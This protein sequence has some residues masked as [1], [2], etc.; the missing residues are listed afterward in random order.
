[1]KYLLSIV[2]WP[3]LYFGGLS[4]TYFALS[5]S[6]P[7][8]WFNVIYFV[9]VSL[10][11]V[12]ERL[13]PHSTDWLEPDGETINNIAHTLLTKGLV[14]A[15]AMIGASFPMVL[16]LVALPP[17]PDASSLWPHAWPMPVQVLLALVIAEFGLYSAHRLA[18]EH[19]A[20]WRFHALHHSVTRL[21]VVNTGRFHFLDSL[22]KIVVSP[23]PLY[24]LGAP[25]DVF[26][27]VGAVTAYT[28][29]LTHCNVE[30]RTGILDYV[31]STP[32][33]HRWHHSINLEE[34]NKNYGENL[35]V[36]DLLLGTYFNPNRPS[37]TKIGITGTVATNF[38]GQLRQP[39]TRKG[40]REIL[41]KRPKVEQKRRESE[42]AGDVGCTTSTVGGGNPLGTAN[43]KQNPS[44]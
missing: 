2:L 36:W 35:V 19:L 37:S 18:H 24:L 30:M 16:A 6:K 43:I 25:L 5:S 27:W 9:F 20:L 32:R 44:G 42:A 21:W 22:F 1:M 13:M 34:G 41:G 26:L 28:G 8:L 3:G 7:I 38:W 17:V 29:L 40:T 39:F 10:L 12:F 31:V 33:L 4:S 23:A 15:A 14:Q 11:A